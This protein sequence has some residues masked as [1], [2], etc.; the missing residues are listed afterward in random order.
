MP[1]L[2]AVARRR[3]VSKTR[4][5]FPGARFELS[6]GQRRTWQGH[7][8]NGE[9]R[10]ENAA[11]PQAAKYRPRGLEPK[12]TLNSSPEMGTRPRPPAKQRKPLPV[13]PTV[14]RDQVDTLIFVLNFSLFRGRP[15]F[16]CYRMGGCLLPICISHPNYLRASSA[17]SLAADTN[18]AGGLIFLPAP[19]ARCPSLVAVTPRTSLHACVRAHFKLVISK[20]HHYLALCSSCKSEA[21]ETKDSSPPPG[22][23]YRRL[24]RSHRTTVRR[25]NVPH[26]V[27][28]LLASLTFRVKHLRAA[29]QSDLAIQGGRLA[30]GPFD[31]IPT[32]DSR[33]SPPQPTGLLS[34]L[35]LVFSCLVFFSH[36]P[37]RQIE[38]LTYGIMMTVQA[39]QRWSP[40]RPPWPAQG[41]WQSLPIL[42]GRV[43]AYRH[44]D[45]H[46]S[47]GGPA[48]CRLA[49]EITVA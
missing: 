11:L 42:P 34:W 29:R 37:K 40:G 27:T 28:L 12:S 5:T 45:T 25:G 35:R 18:H 39:G 20:R 8:E 17:S 13:R 24:V 2:A 7:W 47:A 38:H 30:A 44:D 43:K 31:S 9:W 26:R 14:L 16:R 32:P 4:P 3:S 15:S 19:G 49:V 36:Q 33:S 22:A 23:L 1:L 48:W 41:Y 6:G 21:I 46:S 10:M